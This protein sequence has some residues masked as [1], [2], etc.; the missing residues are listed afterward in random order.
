MNTVLWANLLEDGKVTSDEE[1]K[2]ALYKHN[3]KL[4]RISKKLGLSSFAAICD[5]TDL[6]FNLGDDE[7]PKGMESTNEIMALDGVWISAKDAEKL[8][9]DLL[10]H[11]QANQ[12]RFGLFSN[13]HNAVVEELLETLSYVRSAKSPLAKFNFS[14][15]M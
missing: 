12:V 13:D 14:V 10:D 8:I 11:V 5:T 2:Y 7:L 9:A 4:D 3:S 15:V 6:K 1:D